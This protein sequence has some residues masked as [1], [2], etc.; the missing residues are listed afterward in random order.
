VIYVTE[1]AVVPEKHEDW[2][3]TKRKVRLVLESGC[4]VPFEEAV[5]ALKHHDELYDEIIGLSLDRLVAAGFNEKRGDHA[6]VF[7]SSLP[8]K[9]ILFYEKGDALV[10]ESKAGFGA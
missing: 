10:P 2:L 6:N 3:T 8:N 7:I 5:A 9:L 4:E 1:I